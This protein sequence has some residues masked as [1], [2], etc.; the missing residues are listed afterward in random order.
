MALV[1]FRNRGELTPW[2]AL[3]EMERELSRVFSD[4]YGDNADLFNSAWV[5]QAD[6]SETEEEYILQADLPGLKREEVEL[7]CVDNTVNIKGERK[8][9]V[10]EEKSGYHRTERRYGAFQRS[11]EIPGGFAA[12]KVTA[13]FEDGVLTVHLPKREESKPKQIKVD[14][15]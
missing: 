14:V 15:K 9:E 5:P 8:H 2:S 10:E 13:S 11:F 4:Y 3:R 7:V 6:L 12:D 1:R